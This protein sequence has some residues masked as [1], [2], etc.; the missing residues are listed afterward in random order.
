L[1]GP[2]LG[3]SAVILEMALRVTESGHFKARRIEGT[4]RVR[5]HF[6]DT[7]GQGIRDMKWDGEDLLLV[8]G[9]VLSGNGPAAI[10]RLH[11]FATRTEEGYVGESGQALVQRLPYRE[12]VDHPEALVRWDG[13]DW[14]VVH[15]SP[16]PGRVSDDPPW[17]EGDVWRL[18]R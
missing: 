14:L 17:V 5:K 11:G 9:P 4:S 15:D 2:V 1:R 16:A 7:D 10:L 12:T 18:R 13:E 6:V 3:E 8:T